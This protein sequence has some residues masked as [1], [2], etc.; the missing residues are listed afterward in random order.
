MD[1]AIKEHI[2]KM[3]NPLTTSQWRVI[4]DFMEARA[5]QEL[6][7]SK[8]AQAIGDTKFNGKYIDQ[9]LLDQ[10]HIWLI[11]ENIFN[12]FGTQKEREL[13]VGEVEEIIVELNDK[14]HL[15]VDLAPSDCYLIATAIHQEHKEGKLFGKGGE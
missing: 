8:I 11:A 13:D 4:D 5:L 15:C 14:K 1:K 3:G 9:S 2:N 10:E 12:K 6:N 7:K